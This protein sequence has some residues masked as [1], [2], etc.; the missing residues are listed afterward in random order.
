M[1][2]KIILFIFTFTIVAI[3]FII[4]ITNNKNNKCIPFSG[5]SYN[6][7]FVTNSN[8]K[9]NS[10]RICIACPPDSYDKLPISLRDGYKF[11]G[12]YYDKELKNKVSAIKTNEIIPITK[13]DKN[14]CIIGYYDIKLYAKWTNK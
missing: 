12:W 8:Q 14:N 1:K 11:D 6:L 2:K 9:I 3:V 5:G 4:I 10:I 7:I 13:K